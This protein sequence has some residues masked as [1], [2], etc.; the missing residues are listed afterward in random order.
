LA[1]SLP[2]LFLQVTSITITMVGT[3]ITTTVGTTTTTGIV[4]GMVVAVIAAG[5]RN[6][7]S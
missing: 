1:H 2:R 5:G 6:E 7:V 4:G 3:I